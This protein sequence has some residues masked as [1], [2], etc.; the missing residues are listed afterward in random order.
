MET[1]AKWLGFIIFKQELTNC[2]PPVKTCS[3]ELGM[4][5][6]PAKR[7]ESQ[8]PPYA[9]DYIIIRG[10]IQLTTIIQFIL[11]GSHAQ[12]G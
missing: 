3:Q 5:S 12:L 9:D 4:I 11:S 1:L 10:F 6:L 7:I 8:T 2:S